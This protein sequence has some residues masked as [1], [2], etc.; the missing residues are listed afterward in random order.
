MS[1]ELKKTIYEVKD[2]LKIFHLLDKEE[3]DQLIP[4]L[5]RMNCPAGSTVFNEGDSGD[6]IGFVTSGKFEVTKQT[7]FKGRQIVLALLSK[8]SFVGELSLIDTQSR[9]ATVTAQEDSQL[10][11]LKRDALDAF[12]QKY[13]YIGIKILKGLNRILAI[14]LRKAVDRLTAVF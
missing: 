14:R 13:P 7:E 12:L 5:E 9:S 11:I 3:L 4:Y 2:Q 8:G 10:I 6:F 1:N